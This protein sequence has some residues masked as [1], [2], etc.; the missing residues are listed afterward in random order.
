MKTIKHLL[1]ASLCLLVLNACE[2][3]RPT[4]QRTY[5]GG[6]V[7]AV[8]GGIAGALL[9][10]ENPWRGGVIGGALGAVA[11]ATI[12][13]ISARAAKEAHASGRPVEY[14]TEDGRTIY[15]ADPVGYDAS[16]KCTKIQE[17]IWQDGKL[18]KEEIKEVCEGTKYERRY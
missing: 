8:L 5:E 4:S 15:R 7:G 14:R 1:F 6:A 18:V 9:D 11:G 13:E 2:T 17:R 16:T 12:T 3:V 10:R